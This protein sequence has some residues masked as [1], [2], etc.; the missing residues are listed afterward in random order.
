MISAA[1]KKEKQNNKKEQIWNMV[2]LPFAENK[3][4]RGDTLV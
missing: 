3:E 1:V 4:G 2:G